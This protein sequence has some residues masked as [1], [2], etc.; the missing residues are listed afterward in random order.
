[1]NFK[2]LFGSPL[3]N[4]VVDVSKCRLTMAIVSYILFTIAALFLIVLSQPDIR[5]SKYPLPC[6]MVYIGGAVFAL[7]LTV[8]LLIKSI[9]AYFYCIK[10]RIEIDL[11]GLEHN[12]SNLP[13]FHRAIVYDIVYV[14]IKLYLTIMLLSF[15][16]G[17]LFFN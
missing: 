1:M 4:G 16:I 9:H 7:L 13:A 2:R 5:P 11:I 6:Y 12:I 17:I 15:F 3:N 8:S 10:N 14:C